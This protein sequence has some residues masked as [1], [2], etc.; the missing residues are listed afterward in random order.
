MEHASQEPAVPARGP[1]AANT[2]SSAAMAPRSAKRW[3]KA[4]SVAVWAACSAEKRGR[5]FG[6]DRQKER[7]AER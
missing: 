1:S 7:K 4:S 6:R 3:K 2:H 5:E